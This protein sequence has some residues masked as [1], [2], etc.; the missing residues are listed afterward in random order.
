MIMIDQWL[1]ILGLGLLAALGMASCYLGGRAD[2]VNATI[3]KFRDAERVRRPSP[4]PGHAGGYRPNPSGIVNPRPPQ[5]G[6][7]ER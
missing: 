4:H 1:V 2:G 3:S 5:G 6:T 7:G